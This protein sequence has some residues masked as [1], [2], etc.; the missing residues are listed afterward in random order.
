MNPAKLQRRYFNPRQ[1]KD[2]ELRK[3]WDKKLGFRA[4]LRATDLKEMYYHRLPEKIPEEPIHIPKVN[5]E[6][7]PIIADLVKK[8][9]DDYHKMFM[10]IKV[11]IFQWT[12]AACK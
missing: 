10:D 1:I 5:E 6:E 11:N 2:V 12:A 8:H 4:N 7:A 9:G 3:R